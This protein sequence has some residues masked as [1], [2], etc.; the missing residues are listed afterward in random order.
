MDVRTCKRCGSLFNFMGQMPLCPACTKALEELFPKVKQFIY[1]NPGA[2]I[3]QVAKE[4][5][6]SVSIIKRWVREERLA[7][8]EGS[9]VGLD[10]EKCG[11]SILTGRYCPECK[12]T[13][14]DEF[15]SM[16][17]KPKVVAAAPKPQSSSGK[18]RFIGK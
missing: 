5:G 8:A 16:Y 12:R 1:D 13:V 2:H 11:K 15:G 3:D 7:F 6:V 4:C 17:Q 10:C 14:Q 9:S 18:M